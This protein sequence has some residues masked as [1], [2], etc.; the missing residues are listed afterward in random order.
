MKNRLIIVLVICM[1]IAS[2]ASNTSSNSDDNRIAI[3]TVDGFNVY[4]IADKIDIN[5]YS[6]LNIFWGD[7]QI[8]RDTVPS[9][10]DLE[11]E[12]TKV[13]VLGQNH[14]YVSLKKPDPIESDKLLLLS[15]LDGKLYHSREVISGILEDIDNDGFI[16]VGG[17][18][19]IEAYCMNCDSAYYNP[20]VIYKLKERIEFDQINSER[21]TKEVFGVYLGNSIRFDT[22]LR[23]RE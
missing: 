1:H 22:V 17:A 14:F 21:L 9:S 11:N 3:G 16:E 10:Y 2:C 20:R 13:I 19:I 12:R 15:I 18:E 23:I 5:F 6:D 4:I 8:F 7:R